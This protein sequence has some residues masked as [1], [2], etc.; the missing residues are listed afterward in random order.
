MINKILT[1][2]ENQLIY[3]VLG[4][5]FHFMLVLWSLSPCLAA[6]CSGTCR[7]H[8]VKVGSSCGELISC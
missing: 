3:S 8:I 4:V 2:T 7:F 1:A 5:G 6:M